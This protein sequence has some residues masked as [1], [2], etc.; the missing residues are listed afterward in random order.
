MDE[1]GMA[2]YMSGAELGRLH[3]GLG[4]LEF[5]RTKELLMERL[6]P[7]PAVVLDVG[8][9][10]GEYA[11]WLAELGYEVYLYDLVEAHI[12]M[13]R[14]RNETAAHR[15]AGA[16]VADARHVPMAA[17]SADAVLLLGP[18]YH[19]PERADRDA[20]LAE[21]RRLLKPGGTL[22]TAHIVPW[23]PLLDNVIHYDEDPRLDDGEICDR[24]SNTA[25]TGLHIGK[26]IGEMYFHR[27]DDA[28][29]EVAAAGFADVSLH[30]VI[31]PCWAVRNLD[32][33]WQN[34]DK[35]E[36]LLR[37]IRLLDGEKSLLG[38]STHF[39]SISR[40]A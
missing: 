16:E 36:T 5:A 31:G 40:R 21:C 39:V 10:Y 4:L 25:R 37:V 19:L 2:G 6:P 34:A 7:P 29:D 28:Q 1:K 3:R 15:L 33:A 13:A 30:G 38:F 20:C 11:F 22:V 17:A 35:R 27:P 12:R 26:V 32:E 23:A 8:G 9:A 24:L 18:L 14:E